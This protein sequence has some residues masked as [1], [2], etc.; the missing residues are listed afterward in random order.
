MADLLIKMS[1]GDIRGSLATINRPFFLAAIG[2]YIVQ[3]AIITYIFSQ[4]RDIS[5]V[6][7]LQISLYTVFTAIGGRL[8]FNE[9]MNIG[10]VIGIMLSLTGVVLVTR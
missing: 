5:T 3:I 2:L 7:A 6:G 8:F 4:E 9:Q 1:L 10:Q